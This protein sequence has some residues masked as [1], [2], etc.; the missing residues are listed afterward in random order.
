MAASVSTPPIN[1]S[2]TALLFLDLQ[3]M[4]RMRTNAPDELYTRA[5]SLATAAR[6]KGILVAHVRVAVDEEEFKALPPTNLAFS[7]IKADATYRA[8]VHPDSPGTQF[9]EAVKPHEGDFVTRKVRYG[10]FLTAPSKEF[11]DE[12]VKRG[13]D[14]LIIGGLVTSGAVLSAV[15]QAADLDYAMIVVEDVC[16][17]R[18]EE[19]HRVLMEKVFPV[20]AQV[21]KA[22]EVEKLLA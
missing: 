20:Q 7:A 12:C 17:D 16:L 10:M 8:A 3:N 22:E 18:D 1:P 21:L 5:A 15:R 19:V 6:S 14:T 11:H 2:K 9:V 13:I 4:T